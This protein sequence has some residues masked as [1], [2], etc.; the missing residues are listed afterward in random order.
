[1]YQKL[2]YKLS[3]V[4]LIIAVPVMLGMLSV[5]HLAAAQAV[6]LPPNLRALP[7]AD[8]SLVTTISG[9]SILRFSATSWNSGLGPLQVV[10][11]PVETGS[12][13]QQVYQE[14]FLSD[15]T[16]FLHF[17]GAFRYHDDHGHM[18]FDDFALYTLQP[19]NAPG[20]SALTGSKVTFCIMDTT[21]IDGGL[22][23]APSAPQYDTCGNEV[24]GISVGWGDTYGSHLPGQDIDVTDAPDGIYA[25]TIEA[26]PNNLLIETDENDNESCT[27][28]SIEK[29][30]TVHVLDDSGAC[31]GALSITPDSAQMGSAVEVL[32]E[33]FGFT[34][35]MN[36]RFER[37]NGPRPVASNVQLISDTDT[38]DQITAT[39][40][41]PYKRK[42]G[43]NPVWDVRVGDSVLKDAF[44]VTR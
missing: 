37:G 42:P 15:G 23:G 5:G 25:L 26:D 32:I 36:I 21:K 35:G 22:P 7:A 33:G 17:A 24:Q 40:T 9:E 34:D 13:K 38:V 28:I 2:S 30:N 43:R 10:A 16:S 3:R 4:R 18:H 14:V 44:T 27:L 19:V 1:V 20:G 29:P 39:V 31:A 8:V 11:G 41:V 6:D 12:G